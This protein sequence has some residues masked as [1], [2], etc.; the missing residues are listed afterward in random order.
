MNIYVPNVCKKLKYITC[1]KIPD[2]YLY[3]AVIQNMEKWKFPTYDP[4]MFT[5]CDIVM[6]LTRKGT[7]IPFLHPSTVVCLCGDGINPNG[8]TMYKITH[9]QVTHNTYI[10]HKI[11]HTE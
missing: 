4:V 1:K 10:I 11:R 9:T 2:R 6:S 7:N 3:G 5:D 8:Q